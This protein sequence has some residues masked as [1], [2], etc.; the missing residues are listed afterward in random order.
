VV[1]RARKKDLLDHEAGKLGSEE[2]RKRIEYSE[3]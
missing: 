3:Y 1:V 2:L